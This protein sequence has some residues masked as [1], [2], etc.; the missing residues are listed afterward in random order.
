M[1]TKKLIKKTTPK[2]IIEKTSQDIFTIQSVGLND[3]EECDA[4]LGAF[5]DRA[6]LLCER[7]KDEGITLEIIKQVAIDALNKEFLEV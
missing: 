7:H 1:A 6:K 5:C 3:A 4:L 2:I